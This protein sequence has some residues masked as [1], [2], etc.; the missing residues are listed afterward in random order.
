MNYVF[1]KTLLYRYVIK[2]FLC[3]FQLILNDFGHIL[4][5]A[6]ICG[7][8]RVSLAKA[9]LN[10]FRHERQVKI[11][12]KNINDYGI[13]KEGKTLA[14]VWF[15]LILYVPV[16]SYGHVGTVNSPNHTIIMGMLD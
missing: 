5:L 16:N 11:L 3:I 15:G 1:E 12:L 10:L 14:H 13:A 9:L 8:D 6:E 7:N 4:T 2:I